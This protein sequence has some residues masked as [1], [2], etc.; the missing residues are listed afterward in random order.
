MES[1]GIDAIIDDR[2]IILRNP[3]GADNFPLYLLRDCQNL[4]IRLWAK[5]K[6]LNR[7]DTTVIETESMPEPTQDPSSGAG[8]FYLSG[9]MEP[10]VRVLLEVAGLET[11][12]KR[13][14]PHAPDL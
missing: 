13:G 14:A 1:L 3:I 2:N 8:P 6:S 7:K 5:L 10:Y 12:R 4:P 11:L 9:D